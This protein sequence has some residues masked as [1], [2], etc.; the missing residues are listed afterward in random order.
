MSS[1]H[2]LNGSSKKMSKTEA[3]LARLR[4]QAKRRNKKRG[5][6]PTAA[7]D[8]QNLEPRQLLAADILG[9][10]LLNDTGFSPS[11]NI[12]NDASMVNVQFD[13]VTVI[14][15]AGEQ[16][17]VTGPGPAST[18]YGIS[19]PLTALDIAAGNVNVTLNQ[20][21]G[22]PEAVT[23]ITAKSSSTTVNVGSEDSL[24]VTL[25]ITAPNLLSAAYDDTLI[26]DADTVGTINL[27]FTFD[28]AM[29]TTPVP[30]GF[31]ITDPTGGT[32]LTPANSFGFI[33]PTVYQLN[34]SLA[35]T[36]H[37]QADITVSQGNGVVPRDLAGNPLVPVTSIST[38]TAI[39]TLN[40]TVTIT[41]DD[42]TGGGVINGTETA[43]LT[44]TFNEPLQPG[45]FTSGDVSF[46]NGGSIGALTQMSPTVYKATYTPVSGIMGTDTVSIAVG[47]F[48][49]AA[50]NPNDVGD[51]L[52]LSVDTIKPTVV[53]ALFD[54]SPL[55][56]DADV[57]APGVVTLTIEFDEPMDPS[58]APGISFPDPEAVATLTSPAGGA[59][60]AGN[61]KYGVTYTLADANVEL[62]DITVDVSVAK[63][64][65][66]N[67]MDPTSE[68]SGT[69][70]DTLTELVT[71]T[72]NDSMPQEDVLPDTTLI[73]AEV[74][75]M[76]DDEAQGD[77]T[78][79]YMIGG[80][81]S[82]TATAG[83]TIDSG[84]DYR[85]DP[86]DA[87]GVIYD[88][89]TGPTPFY[90]G[91]I[92]IPEGELTAKLD[93]D[94]WPDLIWEG[95][96]T[97]TVKIVSV[98]N[99][100][101]MVMDGSTPATVTIKDNETGAEVSI[102]ATD[103]KASEAFQ[104]EAVDLNGDSLFDSDI[105]V[106]TDD[107]IQD[108]F[109]TGTHDV[110]VTDGGLVTTGPTGDNGLNDFGFFAETPGVH[111]N[112][113]LTFSDSDD[114]D[115]AR[116]TPFGIDN[117]VFNL[118]VPNGQYS[119]IHL[120]GA[121]VGGN[122]AVSVRFYYDNGTFAT[123]SQ[124]F[125][126]WTSAASAD[127]YV[128]TGSNDRAEN[129]ADSSVDSND[130][131]I[132][133]SVFNAD[134]NRTLEYIEI[135][136]NTS[137]DAENFFNGGAF[138]FFGATG[139][140]A[141]GTMAE[142][143]VKLDVALDHDLTVELT[144][145]GVAGLGNFG[146]P[147]DGINDY[148]LSVESVPGSGNFDTNLPVIS[149]NKVNVVIP[150][151]LTERAIKLTAKDDMVI[152]G[153][154]VDSF[155]SEDAILTITGRTPDAGPTPDVGADDSA[156][157]EICDDDQGQVNIEYIAPG[158]GMVAEGG[159]SGK[160]KVSLTKKNTTVEGDTTSSSDT[161]IMVDVGGVADPGDDYR[162]T[163]TSTEG[164]FSNPQRVDGFWSKQNDPLIGQPDWAHNS[165]NAVATGGSKH[166]YEVVL[167]QDGR[168]LVDVDN[169][170]GFD[171]HIRIFNGS[172]ASAG[173][174]AARGGS[175]NNGGD[176]GSVGTP[177]DA[178]R[179]TGI[180]PA[181][182]Y[183]IEVSRHAGPDDSP[184]QA[185]R[186]ANL[187]NGDAYLLNIS[188]EN[189]DEGI[190]IPAGQS[191][192]MFNV[193]PIDDMIV[194]G[195]YVSTPPGSFG[196]ESVVYTMTGFKR[197][198]P[199]IMIGPD[200]SADLDIKDNDEAEF[201]VTSTMN[202]HEDPLTT[203]PGVPQDGKFTVTLSKES[204]TDTKVKFTILGY[205]DAAD[206]PG[207]G[208]E[209]LSDDATYG[210]DYT[211]STSGDPADFQFFTGGPNEGMGFI[212]VPAGQTSVDIIVNVI[213]E[214]FIEDDE[215]VRLEF[216]TTSP[217]NMNDPEI[218]VD[219]TEAVVTI[220]DED[221]SEVAINGAAYAEEGGQ[222]GLFTVSLDNPK[223]S[224]T[225][226]EVEFMV[227]T[228][229]TLPAANL[230][231]D[232]PFDYSIPFDP[233]GLTS[234][235]LDFDPATGKGVVRIPAHKPLG[236]IVVVANDDML[237]ELTEY[238]KITLV[239]D[240][241][242][243]LGPIVGDSNIVDIK[244][245]FEM[246]EIELRDNDEAFVKVERIQDGK[247][248]GGPEDP[249]P[250]ADPGG[251]DGQDG[252]FKVSL[253][254][255]D[256]SPAT[257][258]YDIE[259]SYSV[260]GTA[261]P[262]AAPDG[263]NNDYRTLPGTV[264][265]PAGP[266]GMAPIWVDVFDDVVNESDQTV[267]IQLTGTDS[268]Q[269]DL[270]AMDEASLVIIDDDSVVVSI[271]ANDSMARE[272]SDDGQYTL[273]LDTP[274]DNPIVV[275]IDVVTGN[276]PNP[277]ATEGS[278]YVLSTK[279]VTFA[280]FQMMAT[281][282]LDV[283]ND[284]ELEEYIEQAEVIV[285]SIVSAN[286]SSMPECSEVT[287]SPDSAIVDI[288]PDPTVSVR[289]H[290][291]MGTE[292][293]DTDPSFIV[294]LPTISGGPLNGQYNLADGDL[295]VEYTVYIGDPVLYGT[296]DADYVALTGTVVIPQSDGFAKIDVEI[297]EDMI[298]EG[299]EYVSVML[300][301]VIADDVNDSDVEV[302]RDLYSIDR[303][304][305]V[306]RIVNT[307]VSDSTPDG[308]TDK[309][310]PITLVDGREVFGGH[311]VAV[312][313]TTWEVYVVLNLDGVPGSASRE[314]AT[315]DPATGVATAIGDLGDRFS[316][317]AF[318][319]DG[320]LYGV[321]GPGAT[322]SDSL[323]VIDKTDASTVLLTSSIGAGGSQSIDFNPIDSNLLH[324]YSGPQLETLG[325]PGGTPA[326][327]L[328]I[329]GDPTTNLILGLEHAERGNFAGN[330][331]FQAGND[332]GTFTNILNRITI[333][334]TISG[335]VA[336]VSFV[337]IMDGGE[338]EASQGL[339]FVK[340]TDFVKIKD[341]DSGFIEVKAKPKGFDNL[342]D[343]VDTGF[344][345]T[346]KKYVDGEANDPTTSSTDTTVEFMVMDSATPFLGAQTEDSS[347]DTGQ[348]IDTYPGGPDGGALNWSFNGAGIPHT[349]VNGVSDSASDTDIYTFT[350]LN[351]G[352]AIDI[353]AAGPV[354]LMQLDKVGGGTVAIGG[355]SISLPGGVAAG[356][357][358]LTVVTSAVGSYSLDVAVENH[359]IA[360]YELTSDAANDLTFLGSGLWQATI[361]AGEESI[362]VNVEVYNDTQVEGDEEVSLW[363]KTVAAG[364]PQINTGFIYFAD[365]TDGGGG[366]NDGIGRVDVGGAGLVKLINTDSVVPGDSDPFGVAIDDA[367][368]K[369]YWTDADP[370]VEGIYRANL[371]GTDPERVIDTGFDPR[372]LQV[373]G[374]YVY[375]VDEETAELHRALKDGSG[376]TE[377]VLDLPST[378]SDLDD[379]GVDSVNNKV[380]WV[381][382]G[383]NRISRAK[384][385]RHPN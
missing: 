281:V 81:A 131:A 129:D 357:Y 259:V 246:D 76:V 329:T 2:F 236:E 283:R 82:D 113:Q 349:I 221:L 339:A 150:A 65:A 209:Q 33:S 128:L 94:M 256:G 125:G 257:A 93:I 310:V 279:T 305:P 75:F 86:L 245:G 38:G 269:I 334:P 333:T 30:P 254:K 112:V 356:T 242:D 190:L 160:I 211:L 39:D 241:G 163:I 44:F 3:T 54:I 119:E 251:T 337:G 361:P 370:N 287:A 36:G 243:P 335:D 312:D 50:G 330:S 303:G 89:T 20:N 167:Y 164:S 297:L 327:A 152:E 78:I 80:G 60:F 352:D 55:I 8:Y 265:I 59:W 261:D 350:V 302:R 288:K 134:P 173:Q 137:D 7:F 347:S 309:V 1:S 123:P 381:D 232:T 126:D 353:S 5:N 222:N 230:P 282:D 378:I 214:D 354:A 142:Y 174:D 217:P 188:I 298:I 234:D 192:T 110:Y 252:Q 41:S 202:G 114:G 66:G 133:G 4:K 299:E 342:D 10:N 83:P 249:G 68:S 62:D 135:S 117:D 328:P 255:A 183:I 15:S 136:V 250:G 260:G 205:N 380:Y 107:L 88:D 19:A 145:S 314:L 383:L 313:P 97:F 172:Q 227:M 215:F 278:D 204:S 351:D 262:G 220:F 247:E 175:N 194:E 153:G 31:T 143:T 106:N 240:Q 52:A 341:N 85:V 271:T 385:R 77:T 274:S 318:G 141:E 197:T 139:V 132:F 184:A 307:D 154:I 377:D 87:P 14:P 315:I 11:D 71:F 37:E 317:I 219:G 369:I 365:N 73:N 373:V 224:D 235:V 130:A 360:D 32:I 168:L 384:P 155:G 46:S 355:G 306:L 28:E 343:T 263:I 92:T 48:N 61:T 67:V 193:D 382:D 74:T 345:I 308:A 291:M 277:D 364:D 178:R 187:Q 266:M 280:P 238:I 159:D 253:V 100:E 156:T 371:D 270:D 286:H 321:T 56:K 111:P 70:I 200:N 121:A 98:T 228:A 248:P 79:T 375:W 157:A 206:Y 359:L 6:D 138:A 144:A 90:M 198:D 24:T 186:T 147:A 95:D 29:D 101:E 319:P 231:G 181:G 332:L 40:P 17:L 368:G 166:Y 300:K 18:L 196:S 272:A 64:A 358:K 165:V 268:N 27:Q 325:L 146:D 367:E 105:I 223:L 273:F 116:V 103:D 323:F 340:S 290:E 225:H 9:M 109:D 201:G 148:Y 115:N 72:I 26:T 180:L 189:F 379:L 53:S 207:M 376:T 316:D 127:T 229:D 331:F 104:F 267:E 218:T 233:T 25:D 49:D 239:D 158:S 151:G 91:S 226:T 289:A 162:T 324:S 237:I 185:G 22:L 120:F 336:D 293:G 296:P 42:G 304:N 264:T 96:E 326:T 320:T 210:V 179:Q 13:N 284:A 35:D 344:N 346:I 102:M 124:S 191:M 84:F 285:S 16:I 12:T 21:G 292:G 374:D 176:P 43:E 366:G 301:E 372:G 51:S 295:T 99:T 212:T 195:G 34:Y 294:E 45:S 57:V 63:D 213:N 208:V 169:T 322:V 161:L 362:M 58:M 244:P 203:P 363:M 47:A 348:D 118:D 122:A 216:A 275:T 149:G 182:R 258:E 311:G 140:A 69:G 276:G 171:S 23:T 170:N 338:L 177:I 199:D 108:P